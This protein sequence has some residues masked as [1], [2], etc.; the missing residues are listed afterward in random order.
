MSETPA[1]PSAFRAWLTLVGFACRRHLRVR[2][3]VLIALAMLVLVGVGMAVE[4][5]TVGWESTNRRPRGALLTN[6][7][8]AEQLTLIRAALPWPAG[9]TGP[10]DALL[11]AA[12]RDMAT[13]AFPNF[14]R[15]VFGPFLSFLVPLWT[16]AF[17]VSAIGGEREART[18]VWQL[19]RPLPRWS[20]Y[21]AQFLGVLPWVFLLNVGGFFA[22]CSIAGPVGRLAFGLYWPAVLGGAAAFAAVFTLAGAAFR[23]PAV[24]CL[25]YAFFLETLIGSLPGT[26]KRCSIS[27]YTRCLMYGGAQTQGHT[28]ERESVFQPVDEPFAWAALVGITVGVTLIGM[29]Y[30]SRSEYRDDA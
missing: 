23:R 22:L 20:V 3:M 12:R 13:S 8:A 9:V 14:S 30:F 27:F 11:T 1:P 17:A 4:T 2:Q 18:L 15:W 25:L 24:V 19:T 26:L 16:L 7:Q 10:V 21:L 29:W 6:R 28:P 5:V